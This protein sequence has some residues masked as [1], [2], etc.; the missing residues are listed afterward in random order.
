ML[1]QALGQR[2]L[3]VTECTG[4]RQLSDVN[5][6]DVTPESGVLVEFSAAL[7]AGD[8]DTGCGEVGQPDKTRRN[9]ENQCFGSA[10]I[11]CFGSRHAGSSHATSANGSELERKNLNNTCQ[12]SR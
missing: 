8:D 10:Y 5:N 6:L 1:I 12:L 11:S 7:R 3:F 2:K 4:M 9:C